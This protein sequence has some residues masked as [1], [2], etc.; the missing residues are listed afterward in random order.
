[1]VA[2]TIGANE[3]MKLQER[4]KIAN[5]IPRFFLGISSATMEE[6]AAMPLELKK[7]ESK[8]NPINSA[9]FEDVYKIRGSRLQLYLKPHVF[10]WVHE[11]KVFLQP[12]L[13]SLNGDL[14]NGYPDSRHSSV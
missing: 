4:K 7:P 11:P 9:T 8:Y 12:L 14:P 10:F 13:C 3:L 6:L 2:P 5:P 1:M